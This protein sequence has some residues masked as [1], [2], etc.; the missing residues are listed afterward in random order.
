M[1]TQDWY[2]IDE[3]I[4]DLMILKNNLP[5]KEFKDNVRVKVAN[6]CEDAE[7]VKFLETIV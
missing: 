3:M 6:R 4:Q 5:S 1:D 2:M 7:S